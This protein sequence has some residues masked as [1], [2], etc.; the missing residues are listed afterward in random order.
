MNDLIVFERQVVRKIYGSMKEE[1]SW[2]IRGD[3]EINL[4]KGRHCKVFRVACIKMVW[5]Y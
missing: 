2:R 4:I 1:G 5:I 3:K